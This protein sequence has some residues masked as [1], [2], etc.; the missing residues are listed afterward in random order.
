M[1]YPPDF[2][3]NANLE[4]RIKQLEKIAEVGRKLENRG[5][6]LPSGERPSG[7]IETRTCH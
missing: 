7:Q 5:S 3:I 2:G 4:L 6:R 1:E